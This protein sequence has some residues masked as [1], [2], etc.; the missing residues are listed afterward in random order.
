MA[1]L[2]PLVSRLRHKEEGKD[3]D[4]GEGDHENHHD[5]EMDE[6]LQLLILQQEQPP[7]QFQQHLRL[8]HEFY[9]EG[10]DEDRGDCVSV[11]DV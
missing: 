7:Y 6:V 1:P 8:H 2:L 10:E 5:G 3:E 11:T 9:V 4:E